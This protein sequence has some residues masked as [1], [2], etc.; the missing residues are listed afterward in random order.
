[1]SEPFRLKEPNG[2]WW[3]RFFDRL[4]SGPALRTAWNEGFAKGRELGF[5]EGRLNGVQEAQK[6][7]AQ[8]R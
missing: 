6:L 7:L 2:G 3:A 1:M 4:A 8:Y 5:E